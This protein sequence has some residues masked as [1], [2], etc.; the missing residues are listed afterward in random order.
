MNQRCVQGGRVSYGKFWKRDEA[1]YVRKNE[2]FSLIG[3]G[4]MGLEKKMGFSR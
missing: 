4:S 3:I 1:W 2:V